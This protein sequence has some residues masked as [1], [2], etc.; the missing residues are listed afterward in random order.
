MQI[1][2]T[3]IQG[4]KIPIANQRPKLKNFAEHFWS[5]KESLNSLIVSVTKKMHGCF[6]LISIMNARDTISHVSP[7]SFKIIKKT[8]MT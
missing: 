6:I 8:S 2:T 4:S 1:G 5:I 3:N 7:T